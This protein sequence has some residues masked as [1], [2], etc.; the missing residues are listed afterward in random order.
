MI[1][2]ESVATDLGTRWPSAGRIESALREVRYRRDKALVPFLL[3]GFPDRNTFESLLFAAQATGADVVEVGLPCS[4]P[5][6]DGPTIRGASQIALAGGASVVS[7]LR[8]VTDCRAR[9]LTVPLLL[10]TYHE[11]LR[12]FGTASLCRSM[13]RAGIDGLLVADLAPE[14]SDALMASTAA[15]GLETVFLVTPATPHAEVPAIVD[16]CRG[17]VYCVSAEGVTGGETTDTAP[18]VGVVTR[19][20]RHTD[21]PALVGFGVSDAE[22]ARR[23]AAVSDG[24]IVGSALL[25]AIGDR[26]GGEAVEAV[27]GLLD[28]LRSAVD[29]VSES[30]PSQG[31]TEG[32]AGGPAQPETA[33]T[34]RAT[35][36]GSF[37][38]G[39]D[40][41]PLLTSTA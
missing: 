21:L 23:F 5:T 30:P 14:R 22:S 37:T 9:G 2:W 10:M 13:A 18:A 1:C 4:D 17:F 15:F 11:P 6:G 27:S 29:Q 40:S 28:R 39:D 24:V 32:R 8:S 34:N 7:L 12:A 33:A 41:T 38:P 26:R 3:Y 36:S 20:R 35:R 25:R 19:V 31:V 16:R